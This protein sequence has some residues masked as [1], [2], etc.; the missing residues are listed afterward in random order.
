MR[1]EGR[2]AA[3]LW[4]SRYCKGM[5]RGD[6]RPRDRG[7]YVEIRIAAPLERVWEL[8]QE[9]DLHARWDARFSRI[10]PTAVRENGAQEFTYELALGGHTIR[11]TGV[12]LGEKRAGAG[13]RTSALLFTTD[14]PLSPLGDGRG[15]WRYIPT[16]TGIR[17]I[18]GYDYEPGW[19]PIGRLLDPIITRPLV[20]WLTA[21]SFDRLRMWAEQGIVPERVGWWRGLFGGPRASARNCLSSPPLR[22]GAHNR[23]AS[24]SAADATSRGREHVLDDAPRTLNE[25][26]D[27]DAIRRR[28][29]GAS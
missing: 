6:R 8:T 20:W 10:T 17:F 5:R 28:G 23:G 9:P 19:G 1:L 11:G 7:L 4:L 3:K 12:S 22:R 15:Y 25:L 14:D 21:W 13:Q 26:G 29:S 27:V 18:T 24:P 16:E 2:A